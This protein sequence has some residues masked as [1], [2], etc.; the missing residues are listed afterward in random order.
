MVELNLALDFVCCSCEGDVTVK[1]KCEGKGLAAGARTVA[2]AQIPCPHCYTVNEIYFE[3]SGT[4][5]DVHPYRARRQVVEL[6]P[7][8]N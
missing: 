6:V 4:V 5:R 3:P 7:S 1:L 8:V 2:A